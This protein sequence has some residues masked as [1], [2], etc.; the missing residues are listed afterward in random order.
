M[1]QYK[2]GRLAPEP[3]DLAD[4][5]EYLTEALPDPPADIAAPQLTYPMADNDQYG[6]CTIAAVVHTDQATA[7][8]TTEAWKYPGDAAVKAEYFKLTGGQDTGLVETNVLTA[9]NTVGLFGHKLAAFAPINVKHTKVIK[10]ATSLIG[11][12]YTG[13]QIPEPAE[14][15]FADHEPWALTGTAAD[16]QIE[17]GHAVP[18]VGYNATGPV[19]VTW[20]A[21]QQVTW[22][23]WLKYAEEAYA[24]ITAEVKKR[25]KLHGVNFAALDKDLGALRAS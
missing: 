13:V 12:V 16:D 5:T 20:G 3:V 7:H 15:Q 10:Q 22:D 4:F 6:D 21:L 24:V 2:L 9:W 11:A 1:N 18:I 25:G 19:V 17:G 14:Q 23:W 8:L